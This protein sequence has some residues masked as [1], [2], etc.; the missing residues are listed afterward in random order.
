MKSS[1][2]TLIIVSSFV[3]SGCF[4]DSV[5]DGCSTC[6][7]EDAAYE[8]IESEC[9]ACPSHHREY[10]EE[11]VLLEEEIMPES[12]LFEETIREEN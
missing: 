5:H 4:K 11:E 12:D 6:E 3:L 8:Q 9:S 10:P 2:L 1:L 7:R